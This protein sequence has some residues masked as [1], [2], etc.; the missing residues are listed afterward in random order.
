MDYPLAHRVG[1]RS[2]R[3][4]WAKVRLT[5]ESRK[6]D[7][8]LDAQAMARLARIDPASQAQVDLM[9]IP[10][11][12]VRA[13][14]GLV[15]RARGPAEGLRRAT[16]GL[17]CTQHESGKGEGLSSELQRAL[18]PLLSAIEELSERRLSSNFDCF[19]SAS[20]GNV[21]PELEDE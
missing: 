18:E 3:G 8:R 5:G 2:D 20:H 7:H 19:R 9:M 12:A 15:N 16:A 14:T 17:Q 21:C 10:A 6:K 11:R 1:A 13:R 4:E